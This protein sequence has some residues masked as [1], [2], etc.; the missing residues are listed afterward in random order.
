MTA[1]KEY[2]WTVNAHKIFRWILVVQLGI[3]IFIGFMTDDLV[4]AFVVGLP[5]VLVPIIFS[6]K[7]PNSGLS[8][9]VIAIATQLMTALHIQ[10]SYGMT[11]LHFEVF[12]VLAFLIFFRDWKVVVTSTL[13][14]AVHHILFFVIQSN[15]AAVFIFESNRMFFYILVIHAL[16]A[17][18]E[19]TLLAFM[20]NKSKQEAIAAELLQESVLRIMGSDGRINLQ[21]NELSDHANLAEFNALI[22]GFKKLIDQVNVVGTSLVGVV[23]KVKIASDELD[24][25]V[26]QQNSQVSTISSA[27]QNMTRSIND[28][29]TLSQGAN[30]IA[31]KARTD[32]N[33]TRDSIEGVSTNIAQLKSTLQTTSQAIQDLS[34]KCTNI[35][36]VMQSIKS[37]AEQTNLLALN[38]A[39]ESARAGEHGRGFAVVADEVRNLAIKSKESAE[40]IELITSQLTDSANHSVLN[41]NNCVSMVENAVDSSSQAS[42]NMASVLSGINEVN[43]NLNTVAESSTEQAQTSESIS[44]SAQELVQLFG[45]EKVQVEELKGDIEQLNKL[46]ID[47]EVQLRNFRV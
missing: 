18:A 21:V 19:G 13:T 1:P 37:V 33:E 30:Q 29:A 20:A 22:R 24:D 15:G 32:T 5:V 28:V 47:L 27:M 39:I 34:V 17:L 38:A 6:L 31:D 23:D 36:E 44:Q 7:Q 43:H 14:V 25:S 2:S 26:D 41:M 4:T 16:F 9:H 40:E 46:A 45:N 11:E 42:T 35:S 3:S 8:A 12:V 10:Q